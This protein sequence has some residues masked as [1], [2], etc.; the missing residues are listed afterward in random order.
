[1]TTAPQ[2]AWSDAS[3]GPAGEGIDVPAVRGRGVSQSQRLPVFHSDPL[4]SGLREMIMSRLS[5]FHLLPVDG[6][7]IVHGPCDRSCAV[8]TFTE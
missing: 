7:L 8:I 3:Q 5:R 4:M 2:P 1:V 6:S